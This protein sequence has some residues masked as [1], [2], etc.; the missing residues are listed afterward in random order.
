MDRDR[1]RTAILGAS[2]PLP[3][4]QR[5]AERVLIALTSEERRQL[6]TVSASLGIAPSMLVRCLTVLG[7]EELME[8]LPPEVGRADILPFS[9]ADGALVHWR[10]ADGQ[11]SAEVLDPS[12]VSPQ[13]WVESGWRVLRRPP[14]PWREVAREYPDAFETAEQAKPG[15]W[16]VDICRGGASLE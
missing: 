9:D 1:L 7:V 14:R 11:E 15:S 12:D 13:D 2:P 8:E 16:G 5:R 3:R 4:G 10:R 6:D